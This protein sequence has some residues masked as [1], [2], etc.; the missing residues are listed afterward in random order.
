MP[1]PYAAPGLPP[2]DATTD[3]PLIVIGPYITT[4]PGPATKSCPP[5]DAPPPPPTAVPAPPPKPG[6]PLAE[7]PGV[8]KPPLPPPKTLLPFCD[9]PLTHGAPAPPPPQFP[10]PPGDPP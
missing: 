3:P 2:A 7:Q 8:W 6:C 1:E 5:S 9:D 4:L 10:V